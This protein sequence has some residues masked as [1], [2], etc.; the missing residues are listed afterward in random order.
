MSERI[1]GFWALVYGSPV[2]VCT[3][4]LKIIIMITILQLYNNT[5]QLAGHK[6][7]VKFR[8]GA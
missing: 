4:G 1:H 2:N 6:Q 3:S 7:L 8:R 5:N